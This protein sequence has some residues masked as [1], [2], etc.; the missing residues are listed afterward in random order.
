MNNETKNMNPMNTALTGSLFVP[1]FKLLSFTIF[2][3]FLLID[4]Y[5]VGLLLDASQF[6]NNNNAIFRTDTPVT[7][8]VGIHV[9]ITI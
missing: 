8:K 5:D 9:I 1:S 7:I 3:V 4:H 6:L 2:L